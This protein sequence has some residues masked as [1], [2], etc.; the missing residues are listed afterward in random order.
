MKT[1]ERC[2][3]SYHEWLHDETGAKAMVTAGTGLPEPMI[4]HMHECPEPYPPEVARMFLETCRATG[5]PV[6]QRMK[7]RVKLGL[8]L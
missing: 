8:D 5:M 2:G 3:M 7:A 1:C 6:S 4:P